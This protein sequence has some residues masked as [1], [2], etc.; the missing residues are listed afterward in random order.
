MILRMSWKNHSY[1]V[2]VDIATSG[3]P[4][5][6]IVRERASWPKPIVEDTTLTEFEARKDAFI[7]GLEK[8]GYI[9]QG[10]RQIPGTDR[11]TETTE[12][13]PVPKKVDKEESNG[14]CGND[15]EAE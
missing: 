1:W 4:T 8:K 15:A 7:G 10:Y 5:V 11:Q 6:R 3:D 2:H 12:A 9:Y 13:T 14:T